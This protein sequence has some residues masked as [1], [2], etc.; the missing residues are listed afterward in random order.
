VFYA[1]WRGCSNGRSAELV[2]IAQPIA[3]CGDVGGIGRRREVSE[4]RVRTRGVEVCDP[5]RD[6]GS[7]VVEIEEQRLIEQFVAHAT[8][9]ALDEAVLHGLARRNQV[10]VDAVV[11]APGEHGVAGVFR[12]VVGDDHARLAMPLDDRRQLACHA[13]A[14]DRGV[15]DCAQTLLGHVI[16]DVEDAEAPPVGELLVDKVCRPARVW[17]RLDLQSRFR[18]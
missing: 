2:G 10:P 1:V 5:G 6:L 7:G 3:R 14:R 12:A 16:D 13:P 15:R 18:S 4:R 8:V 9:E 11:F 17:L